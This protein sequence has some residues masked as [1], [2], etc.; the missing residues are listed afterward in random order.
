MSEFPRMRR[1]DKQVTR[2]RSFEMLRAGW[3]GRLATVAPDGEPY[4]CP[5]LFVW[6]AGEIWFHTS[7]ATGHLRRNLAQNDRAC[8]EI[9]EPGEVFAYGR[10]A[11]DTGIAY[12]SV[13][14]FGRVRVI[15]GEADKSAF[16]DTFMQ[17]YHPVDAGR[18]RGFY[19]RLGEVT[20]FAMA[21]D[22]ITGKETVLPALPER[23]PASDN[24]RT[25]RAEPPTG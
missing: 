13:I 20:V 11:C 6:R 8:F 15:D 19:P 4:V 22:R 23:W 14:A 16:F 5:L 10:F 7:A 9:D 24:T 2:E 17:R 25:P 18:P 1:A 12:R 21:L 3:C